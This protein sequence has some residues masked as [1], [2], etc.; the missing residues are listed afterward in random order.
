MPGLPRSWRRDIDHDPSL[1]G[2]PRALTHYPRGWGM[3]SNTPFR[4]YKA[5]TLAGG[6]RV[7]FVMSWPSGLGDDGGGLHREFRYVTDLLPTVL[8]LTGVRATASRSTVFRSPP[9]CAGRTRPP[10]D[11]S[12]TSRWWATA[13][14]SATSGSW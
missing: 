7:P 2:S 6:V 12:S 4:M 11:L 9:R 5:H 10:R 3:A 1:I 8:D 14:T 13:P